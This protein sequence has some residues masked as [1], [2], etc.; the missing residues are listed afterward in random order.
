MVLLLAFD[1]LAILGKYKLCIFLRQLYQ[2]LLLP[3]LWNNNADLLA[4]S[5][6]EPLLNDSISSISLW[7]HSSFGRNGVPA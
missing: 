3:F 1:L 4:F 2:A 6:T 7:I 5:G